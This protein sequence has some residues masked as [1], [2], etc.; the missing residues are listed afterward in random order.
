MSFIG[1][2]G[3]GGGFNI[4]DLNTKV[5]V[6]VSTGGVAALSEQNSVIE[7]QNGASAYTWTIPPNSSAAFPIGSWQVLRKTGTGDITLARGA[8]VVFEHENFGDNN[9]KLDGAKGYSVYIE[10]TAAD[11]WLLTGA[12]KTV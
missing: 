2:F 6:K 10:K 1:A 9:V 5:V 7:F 12:I 8:G 3:G 4:N 11:T